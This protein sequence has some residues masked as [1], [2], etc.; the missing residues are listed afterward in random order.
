MKLNTQQEALLETLAAVDLEYRHAETVM[1][2]KLRAALEAEV[3]KIQIRRDVLAHRAFTEGI[4]KS[5]ISV[6]GL[7]TKAT[8]TATAAINNGAR[9][10]ASV[11]AEDIAVGAQPD[12]ATTFEW[13]GDN[14]AF[15]LGDVS[16][17]V[18]VDQDGNFDL[19]GGDW[20]A[21][22]TAFFAEDDTYRR[23]AIAWMGDAQ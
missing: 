8:T 11:E 16:A 12:T 22:A 1:E 18:E 4:P 6:E 21:A 3:H 9:Y 10:A 14:L 20:N 7:H 19:V 13:V 15:T 2:K 17:V 23:A 5:R